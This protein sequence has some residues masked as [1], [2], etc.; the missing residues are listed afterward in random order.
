MKQLTQNLKHGTMLVMEVPQPASKPGRMLIRT[1]YSVISG[2]TEGKTVTDAR[3]SYLDK[4][5]SRQKEVRQVIELSKSNGVLET[6]KLVMNKLE[7]YS[8]LGY[9]AVGRVSEIP[10]DRTDYKVG[11]LV[12]CGGADAAHAEVLSI[13]TNLCAKVHEGTDPRHAALATIAAIAMQ[14]VRQAEVHLGESVVVIGLGLIGQ[15][16]LLLLAAQGCSAIGV[17]VDYRQVELAKRCGFDHAFVSSHEGL[18]QAVMDL[19]RGVGVDAVIITAG[20]TS[21]GPVNLAGEFCR[22]KGKVVIVG[23]VPTGFERKHYYRKELDLRMSS[24]YGPGR[25][26]PL[27]EEQGIDYP[28]GYVRWTEQRNMQAY[29]DLLATGKLNIEPLITHEFPLERAKDAYDMILAKKEHYCAVLLEYATSGEMQGTVYNKIVKGKEVKKAGVGVK[30]AFIGAGSFAQNMILPN[31]KGMVDFV[32]ISTRHGNTSRYVMDK[33]GF[34]YATDDVGKILSD[35]DT[36]TV[37]IMTRHDTHARYVIDALQAG[38]D[39]FVEK[40]LAL[41]FD[42][43]EK[44]LKVYETSNA[45]MMLGFNRRFAPQVVEMMKLFERSQRKAISYRVN[46]GILPSDHWVHDPKVG[47]GRIIGEG[48]HF[49]DLCAFIAGAPIVSVA[50]HETASGAGQRDTVSISLAFANDSSANI[51]YF[52]N[53]S[54]HLSKEYLEVFCNGVSVVIDDFRCMTVYG[55]KVRKSKLKRQDKGHAAEL[56]A[57]VQAIKDGEPAPIPFE[58]IYNSSKATFAVLESI[59]ERKMVHL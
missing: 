52:S 17:D 47:G 59:G 7:A 9:A 49:I 8:S 28:V 39:V 13:G 27:Y 6:Y 53:G 3:K 51:S 38:K 55:E 45:R 10:E 41:T 25:Y 43:L 40:P 4:A 22:K 21:L 57:F 31:L 5:K 29:L 37:F 20:T 46:A 11:D 36:N 16:T 14:G 24:S 30:T 35:G 58:E 15:L 34:D 19:T 26:D 50:A 44:V 32:G 1:L 12:A 54:K 33:Y 18:V 42:E 23:A 48:C 56:K 2:G